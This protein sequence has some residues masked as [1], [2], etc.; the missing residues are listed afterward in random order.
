MLTTLTALLLT[1]APLVGE[2]A[3][4]FTVAD[5]DGTTHTLSKLVEK[6]PVVL[7]FFPRAFTPG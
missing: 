3:P 6:G 5:V 4:D 7:A 1:A 2:L